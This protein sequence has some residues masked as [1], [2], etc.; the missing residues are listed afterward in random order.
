M[1]VGK[2]ITDDDFQ[3]IKTKYLGENFG[4]ADGDAP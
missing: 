3:R 4:L 1:L 2:L